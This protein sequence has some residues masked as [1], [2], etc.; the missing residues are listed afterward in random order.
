MLY[1]LVAVYSFRLDSCV[2][3]LYQMRVRGALSRFSTAFTVMRL[4]LASLV[5]GREMQPI[6]ISSNIYMDQGEFEHASEAWMQNNKETMQWDMR[7]IFLSIFLFIVATGILIYSEVCVVLVQREF[8]DLVIAGKDIDREVQERRDSWLALRAY[9][10]L[11]S[12]G[13][14]VVA[15]WMGLFALCHM[16]T[17]MLATMHYEFTGCYEM[18][19]LVSFV[20]A[21]IWSLFVTGCIWICTRPWTGALCLTIALL[22][23]LA[24]DSGSAAAVVMWALVSAGGAWLFFAY[25]PY[26]FSEAPGKS[27]RSQLLDK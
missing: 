6:D 3:T 27:E 18:A 17:A 23:E 10:S 2:R 8:D 4:N 25:G 5:C 20:I 11:G 9:L 24:I 21:A 7:W 14:M 26:F 13:G 12:V 16:A 19:F 22:G 1:T 15:L